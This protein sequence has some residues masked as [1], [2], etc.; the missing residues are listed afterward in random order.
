MRWVAVLN[1]MV[2][3]I[4]KLAWANH[5]GDEL[6]RLKYIYGEWPVQRPNVEADHVFHEQQG[7]QWA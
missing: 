1:R 4:K 7:G 5:E 6:V 3:A 2:R